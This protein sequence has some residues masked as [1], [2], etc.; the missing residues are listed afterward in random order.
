MASPEISRLQLHRLVRVSL[1][2]L[3][4]VMALVAAYAA[5]WTS[6]REWNRRH[7]AANGPVQIE[8]LEGTDVFVTRGRKKDVDKVMAIIGEIEDAASK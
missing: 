2:S 5:G 3:L 6:H 8:F 1:R 4:I 7:Q